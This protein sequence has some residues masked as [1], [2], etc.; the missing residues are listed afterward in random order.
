MPTL[1]ELIT[2]TDQMLTTL[3]EVQLGRNFAAVWAYDT[4]TTDADPGAATFRL[5]S[6]TL[7]AATFAY[8]DVTDAGGAD[9]TAYIESWDDSTN[10]V[11]GFLTLQ[12][13]ANKAHFAL[14]R[15][16]GPVVS[17]TGYRKVPIQ[18]IASAGTWAAGAKFAL[19][20]ERS[21][22]GAP[23]QALTANRTYFVRKDG[24][25]T[26]TGLIDA[27]GGAFLTIQKALDVVFGELDLSIYTAT[28][29]VRAGTYAEN[30]FVGAP[31]HGRGA[32]ILQGDTTT[33]ANVVIAGTSDCLVAAGYATIDVR[34]FRLNPGVGRHAL[35]ANGPSQIAFRNIEFGATTGSHLLATNGQ[36]VA[37][38]PYSIVGN[39]QRHLYATRAGVIAAAGVTVTL[40]GTPA[41]GAAFAWCDQGGLI[42]ANGNTFSGAATGRRYDVSRNGVVDTAGAAT[43][44]L[45]GDVAGTTAT[46]GVYA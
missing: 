18:H 9:R 17:A 33:P 8:F 27:A 24:A 22:D 2:S 3:Q 46:G 13:L 43:T 28:I 15:I 45:P 32:M 29:Q 20:V 23:R 37:Q 16:T 31:R 12:G 40:S 39:V 36:I 42:I 19:G 30:L 11:K 4:V 41:F 25:D 7:S 38:G 10:P 5:N 44:Y 26:T 34:G 14:Y 35:Y 6:A 21:G 1:A